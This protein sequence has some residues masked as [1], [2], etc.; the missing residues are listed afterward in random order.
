MPNNDL[1]IVQQTARLL[2]QENI[3]V[4]FKANAVPCFDVRPTGRTL[5]LPTFN[6]TIAFAS[7]DALQCHEIGHALF[8]PWDKWNGVIEKYG[9]NFARQYVNAIEDIR[10]ERLVSK[11][12]PGAALTFNRG[13]RLLND[14]PHFAPIVEQ[15]KSGE[16]DL[17][18][19]LY[20]HFSFPWIPIVFGEDEK[21][22]I[23][24]C[25]II[26]SFEQGVT[27]ALELWQRDKDNNTEK[28]EQG[29]EGEEGEEGD[30]ENEEGE[31][32]EQGDDDTEGSDKSNKDAEGDKQDDQDG[33]GDDEGDE[34][35]DKSDKDAEGDDEGDEGSDKGD[36]DGED[37]DETNA[38]GKDGDKSD[39]DDEG[40]GD[41]EGDAGGKKGGD[42]EKTDKPQPSDEDGAPKE[43][44]LM[45]ALE[46]FKQFLQETTTGGQNTTPI[47]V[48]IDGLNNNNDS[49]Y[50]LFKG[51]S[52][53]F[54]TKIRQKPDLSL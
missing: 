5:I 46:E 35:S 2:A 30:G 6:D 31:E 36:Q 11:R 45:D 13:Y 37:D 18:S 29:E 4:I 25:M 8:T 53:K 27:I 28:S 33:E 34:G 26:E 21:E 50:Q 1:G 49:G 24:K 14:H 42:N 22:Y 54:L 19:R 48:D 9:K 32:G 10:I 39:K 52:K 7:L 43:K 15:L 41:T 51:V 3:N 17:V 47:M 40:E 23:K 12:Y 44:N 38:P 16:A 20:A